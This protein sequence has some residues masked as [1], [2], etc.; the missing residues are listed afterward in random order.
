[1]LMASWTENSMPEKKVHGCQKS[2]AL[3][4]H[5]FAVYGTAY[6]GLLINY[7][8]FGAFTKGLSPPPRGPKGPPRY[9]ERR[10]TPYVP[11][12]I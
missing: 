5:E 11:S 3:C 9:L 8:N 4:T 1:M 2:K 12:R 10:L 6:G 7:S